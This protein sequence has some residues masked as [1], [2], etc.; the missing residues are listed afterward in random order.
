VL[1]MLN[2]A[3]AAAAPV[4]DVSAVFEDSHFIARENI[5]AIKDRD[6]GEVRM[7]NVAPKLE[8][9]PGYIERG[10]PRLGEHTDDIYAE[11]LGL[12]PDELAELRKRMVI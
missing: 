9:T 6:L 1:T 3:G 12:T 8:R 11:R 7:Q 10:G 4:Y 5:V 2:D